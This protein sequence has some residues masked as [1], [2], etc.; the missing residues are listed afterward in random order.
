M[1]ERSGYMRLKEKNTTATPGACVASEVE[2]DMLVVV[3]P[4]GRNCPKELSRERIGQAPV[5]VPN[6]AYYRR[7]VAEGSLILTKQEG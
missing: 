1:S 7:L 3:A 5:K 4:D 2:A 6:N